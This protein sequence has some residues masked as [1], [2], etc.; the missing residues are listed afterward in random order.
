MEHGLASS[1]A[2]S[3]NPKILSHIFKNKE[4]QKMY[5]D[6]CLYN[7]K[8]LFKNF[9]ESLPTAPEQPSIENPEGT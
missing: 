8:L 3:K 5:R 6:W 1:I 2:I 9:E 4:D 7:M